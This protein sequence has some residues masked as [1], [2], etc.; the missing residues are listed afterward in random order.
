MIGGILV[1][2][3][4]LALRGIIGGVD[5]NVDAQDQMKRFWHLRVIIFRQPTSEQ[6]DLKFASNSSSIMSA[7]RKNI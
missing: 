4:S 1:S 5:P 2:L 6:R 3:K 7:T